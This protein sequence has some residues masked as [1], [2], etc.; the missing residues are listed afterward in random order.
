LTAALQFCYPYINNWRMFC[1]SLSTK[2]IFYQ[3]SYSLYCILRILI[4]LLKT[5]MSFCLFFCSTWIWTQGFTL[6]KADILPL[7]HSA[8]PISCWV[9][10]RQGLTNCLPRVYFLLISASWVARITGT[11]HLHS[12]YHKSV[13]TLLNA[14]SPPN[15]LFL[16]LFIYCP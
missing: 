4:Y 12:T 7:N 10:S 11:S 2:Y 9:F 6:V 14:F 15:S 8:S 5:F 1:R 16:W 3:L 13:I